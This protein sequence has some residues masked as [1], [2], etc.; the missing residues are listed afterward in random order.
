MSDRTPRSAPAPLSLPDSPNVDWLRKQAKRRLAELRDANP[1]AQLADAQFVVAKQYGFPSWR[2]LK[3]H[4]D[5]LV[6]DGQLFDAAKIGNVKRLAALLDEHPEKL[7]ARAQPYEW[8]LLHHAASNGHLAAVDLLLRR[9]LDVNT[10]EKGDNTYAMHWAAQPV[11]WTWCGGW[12]TP[13]VM[14]SDTVTTMSSTS[15]VGQPAGTDATTP[16]I[17]PLRIFS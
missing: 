1:E 3:A 12:P 4:I 16:P 15:S 5:S 11:T 2:A 8:S 17:V 9:G 10:R 6:T 14:S 7:P 13:G